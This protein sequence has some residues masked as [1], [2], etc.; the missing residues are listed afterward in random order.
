MLR[1]HLRPPAPHE[2]QDQRSPRPN[3]GLPDEG[4]PDGAVP[5]GR[6]V[7]A[8]PNIGAPRE[9]PHADV[10]LHLHLHHRHCA[11]LQET[12]LLEGS[13]RL[14]QRPPGRFWFVGKCRNARLTLAVLLKR[15]AN[16][17]AAPQQPTATVDHHQATEA[18]WKSMA[19]LPDLP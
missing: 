12:V 15:R 2:G 6:P 9:R 8:V 1:V 4:D 19:D 10:L 11:H 17:S 5:G 13:D 18:A 7:R 3:A 16:D 14:V